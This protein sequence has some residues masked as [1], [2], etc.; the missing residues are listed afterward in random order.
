VTDKPQDSS[1]TDWEDE[2]GTL[3]PELKQTRPK[4]SEIPVP[5][6]REFKDAL[7]NMFQPDKPR[8]KRKS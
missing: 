6:L 1:Q 5:K 4:G 2:G 8:R 3:A 7:R